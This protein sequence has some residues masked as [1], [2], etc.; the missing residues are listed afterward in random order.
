MADLEIFEVVS[1]GLSTNS[2]MCEKLDFVQ[3]WTE[4]K[5]CFQ[6]FIAITLA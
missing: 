4:R 2:V 5:I 1:G 6:V 3:N